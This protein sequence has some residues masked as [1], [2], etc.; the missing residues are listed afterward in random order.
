MY[1]QFKARAEGVGAELHRYRTKGEALVF[2]RNF[3]LQEGVADAPKSYAVWVPG[4]FLTGI[5]TDRLGVEVPGLSFKVSRETAADAKIG[6]SEMGWA[7]ADTGSLVA[8][9]T[10]VEQ[11]LAST[12]PPIHIAVIGTERIL[13][14]KAAVFA[15]INPA[16]SRYIAFITGPSRTADIE[17][18]LTIGVHGPK[19]LV[20]VLVDAME[21]AAP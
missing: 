13:P 5:D 14:D 9:Q 8:D 15:R 17:R 16:T 7:L 6:I 10:A 19:R 2:I 21:G 11:R 18:V 1:E 3:L 12:L 4:P 20:I